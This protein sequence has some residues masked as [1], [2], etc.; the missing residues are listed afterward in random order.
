VSALAAKSATDSIPIVFAVGSDPTL[1]GLVPSFRRP[2]GNVTGV[3]FYA[4]LLAAKQIELLREIVPKAATFGLLLNPENA[5]ADLIL[6]EAMTAAQTLGL[7]LVVVRA[8][9]PVQIEPAF[10]ELVRQGATALLLAGEAFLTSWRDRI[11]ALALSHKMATCFASRFWT[12]AGGLLSY[13]ADRIEA[14][15]QAGNYVGRILKGEKAA[16]LPIVQPTKFEMLINMKTAKALGLDIPAT[17]L[18]RA[19]EVIE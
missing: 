17:V 12:E 6:T 9:T 18:A 2:G 8:T 7:R 15:R 14:D 13:G 3:T 16:D 4:N 19:D 10:A 5:N 1:D 11:T